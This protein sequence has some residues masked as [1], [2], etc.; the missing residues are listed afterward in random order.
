M[1]YTPNEEAAAAATIAFMAAFGFIFLIIFVITY[2]IS[3]LLLSFVFKK[4]GED[5][6][7]AWV[8]FYNTWILFEIGGYQ[9]WAGL[10]VSLGASI[11]SAVPFIGWIVSIAALVVSIFVSLNIQKAFNKPPVFILLYIFVPVVWLAIIGFDSSQYDKTKLG[12]AIP[13]FLTKK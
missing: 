4:A 9:G 3:S 6:W 7:K 10:A 11:L 8:P 12:K 13:E 1:D 5:M 2:V